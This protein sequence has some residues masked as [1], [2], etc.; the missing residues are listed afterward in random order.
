MTEITLVDSP[1]RIKSPMGTWK[2]LDLE[3]AEGKTHEVR[4][5]T[6]DGVF[7]TSYDQLSEEENKLWNTHFLSAVPHDHHTTSHATKLNGGLLIRV[8]RPVMHPLFITHTL[9]ES[10]NWHTLILI[11]EGASAKIV[12]R[13]TGTTE[14]VSHI[15]ESFVGTNA[16]LF[17]ANMQELKSGIFL[18]RRGGIVERD[19]TLDWFELNANKAGGYSRI[20]SDLTGKA[21]STRIN[22]LYLGDGVALIDVGVKATHG[23]ERSTS[24]LF[25]RGILGERSKAIYEGELS[26]GEDAVKSEAFQEADT[27]L[28]SSDADVKTSPMLY[29]DNNDVKCSH[30]ATVSRP[31]TEKLFYL[32]ARGLSKKVAQQLLI[33][34]Y[35]WPII[36]AVPHYAQQTIIPL[37]EPIIERY[38]R[39]EVG[40]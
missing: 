11:D 40:P 26:I 10:S 20:Q 12:E 38:V 25:T 2:L 27:L 5:E 35:A 4:Y 22:S 29:I 23:A 34:A 18:G 31:D 7:V 9:T 16:T 39:Q 8:T 1:V 19:A 13:F 30:A 37:V 15:V 6:P 14:R 3:V 33:K 32:Q 28:L 21:A 36:D 24:N 17:Y